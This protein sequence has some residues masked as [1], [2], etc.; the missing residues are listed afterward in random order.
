MVPGGS[1]PQLRSVSLLTPCLPRR[2]ALTQLPIVLN[3]VH[4][5]EEVD[6]GQLHMQHGGQGRTQYGDELGRVCAVMR[7]HQVNGSQLE[8]EEETE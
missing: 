5:G 3:E 6:M 1:S 7:I 2:G 8:K 4:L